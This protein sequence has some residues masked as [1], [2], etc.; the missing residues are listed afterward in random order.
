MSNAQCLLRI[1]ITYLCCLGPLELHIQI[2]AWA[3]RDKV[4]DN[5]RITQAENRELTIRYNVFAVSSVK[6]KISLHKNAR[7]RRPLFAFINTPSFSS[8][9][10]P[11]WRVGS[12]RSRRLCIADKYGKAKKGHEC[13]TLGQSIARGRYLSG[14]LGPPALG[15]FR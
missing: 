8:F 10:A 12:V 3:D 11:I 1:A 13:R 14:V 7:R 2:T 9:L 6:T 4:S 15:W 5:P